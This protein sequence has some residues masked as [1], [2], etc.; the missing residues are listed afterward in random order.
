M[1]CTT[2]EVRNIYHMEF[3]GYQ[4]L[5]WVLAAVL[6]TLP[7]AWSSKSSRHC[8]G[9][10]YRMEVAVFQFLRNIYR[11]EFAVVQFLGWVLLYFSAVMTS[12]GS[13][14]LHWSDGLQIWSSSSAWQS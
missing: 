10:I 9:Y 8:V 5:I 4:S 7:T 14:P 6:F 1:G 3:A 12:T 11:L 2:A 13:R